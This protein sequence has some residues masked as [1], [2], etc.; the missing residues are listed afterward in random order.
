MIN[1]RLHPSSVEF[2]KLQCCALRK[3]T[4][5]SDHQPFITSFLN[6]VRE[7]HPLYQVSVLAEIFEKT[8]RL[9]F[10]LRQVHRSFYLG[11]AAREI[12]LIKLGEDINLSCGH[13]VKEHVAALTAICLKMLYPHGDN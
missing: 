3:A 7:T 1:A 8:T 4:S 12:E 13:A 2:D 11:L 5:E 9:V 10:I 6:K